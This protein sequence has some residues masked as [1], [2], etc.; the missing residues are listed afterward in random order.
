MQVIIEKEP[1]V[2][3]WVRFRVQR[4]PWYMN[5]KLE[6]SL[7][8]SYAHVFVSG[9]V[10]EEFKFHCNRGMYH[11]QLDKDEEVG[12]F[13]L[14]G[15]SA[16]YEVKLMAQSTYL[17]LSI[18]WMRAMGK[19]LAMLLGPEC[20]V[21]GRKCLFG[22]CRWMIAG[23]TVIYQAIRL[24]QNTPMFNHATLFLYSHVSSKDYLWIFAVCQVK[25]I[26]LIS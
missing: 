16:F 8:P 4:G 1:G 17:I 9:M 13:M 2:G 18:V 10:F 20:D 23:C 25:M 19:G 15:G 21:V 7:L 24:G 12:Y 14:G 6:I 26:N 5:Q 11:L 3:F 22:Y